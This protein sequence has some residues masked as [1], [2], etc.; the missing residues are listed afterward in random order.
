MVRLC[1]RVTISLT[2]P[3]KGSDVTNAKSFLSCDFAH[4][5]DFHMLNSATKLS[6]VQIMHTMRFESNCIA[7]LR[8][9]PSES[10]RR[11]AF[12]SVGLATVV[13]DGDKNEDTTMGKSI[14]NVGEKATHIRTTM[15]CI[16]S[17][18]VRGLLSLPSSRRMMLALLALDRG[19]MV[20]RTAP[21]V[22][23]G[24]GRGSDMGQRKWVSECVWYCAPTL[25]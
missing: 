18:T 20:A 17:F 9:R 16:F 1:S 8:R 2:R 15:N 7:G 25:L 10:V 11:G 5:V 13:T 12:A 4:C 3:S 21:V 23:D 22:C 24:G 19:A 14:K 6:T